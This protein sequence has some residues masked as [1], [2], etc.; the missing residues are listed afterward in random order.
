[1]LLISAL[2]LLLAIPDGAD[3]KAPTGYT[4]RILRCNRPYA[5]AD[6]PAVAL[7]PPRWTPRTPRRLLEPL[8]LRGPPPARWIGSFTTVCADMKAGAFGRQPERRQV[9]PGGRV[10][11]G[12]FVA[13]AAS[14]AA[15]PAIKKTASTSPPPPGSST[16]S[17]KGSRKQEG[18]LSRWDSGGQ[19]SGRL[20]PS[21]TSRL[22]RA[23]GTCSASPERPTRSSPPVD[24][25]A[26]ARR[27]G[28]NRA[29]RTPPPPASESSAS[30]DSDEQE[31]PVPLP[32]Q[33][34]N[35]HVRTRSRSS[36]SPTRVQPPARQRVSRDEEDGDRRRG[37]QRTSSPHRQEPSKSD[38]VEGTAPTRPAPRP[39]PGLLSSLWNRASELVAGNAPAAAAGPSDEAASSSNKPGAEGEEEGADEADKVERSEADTTRRGKRPARPVVVPALVAPALAGVLPNA[40]VAPAPARS[41]APSLPPPEPITYHR[42]PA[43]HPRLN[44]EE[45]P[46]FRSQPTPY[47]WL[48]AR[49]ESRLLPYMFLP[50]AAQAAAYEARVRAQANKAAAPHAAAAAVSAPWPVAAPTSSAPPQAQA[51]LAASLHPYV[52]QPFR[53]S[54][55]VGTALIP[56]RVQISHG[57]GRSVDASARF[58]TRT[59]DRGETRRPRLRSA[60]PSTATPGTNPIK[61]CERRTAGRWRTRARRRHRKQYRYTSTSRPVRLCLPADQRTG[62]QLGCRFP[63]HHREL[64]SSRVRLCSTGTRTGAGASLWIPSSC[65]FPC[66]CTGCCICGRGV[67]CADGARATGRVLASLYRDRASASPCITRDSPNHDFSRRGIASAVGVCGHSGCWRH[68]RSNRRLFCAARFGDPTSWTRWRFVA[69]SSFP[70]TVLCGGAF[71]RASRT[72][73]YIRSH[74]TRTGRCSLGNGTDADRIFGLGVG[75]RAYFGYR[76]F[77]SRRYYHSA[78]ITTAASKSPSARPSRQFPRL[79]V[80]GG[81]VRTFAYVDNISG[82]V[83]QPGRTARS[84]TTVPRS[85]CAAERSENGAQAS[86]PRDGSRGGRLCLAVT[87]CSARERTEYRRST[88]RTRQQRRLAADAEASANS[89]LASSAVRPDH[90]LAIVLRPAHNSASELYAT[91]AHPLCIRSAG[92]DTL[93]G[94][95]RRGCAGAD[96]SDEIDLV[97]CNEAVALQQ[98]GAVR[99][100]E[101]ASS[102]RIRCST[103]RPRRRPKGR[104][105]RYS[106]HRVKPFYCVCRH[107]V[108]LS[109]DD[110]SDHGHTAP[111]SARSRQV[112]VAHFAQ[113]AT[114]AASSGEHSS[115]TGSVFVR[116]FP[117]VS[118]TS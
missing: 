58:A 20:P 50:T 47:D 4:T 90:Q 107:V 51:P 18:V 94:R 13:P 1:M 45:S 91:S 36:S 88:S 44:H 110:S 73:L 10:L 100:G 55:F 7:E 118:V 33:Q 64:R 5:R 16:S 59:T 42:S 105:S 15:A 71:S 111:P 95:S 84:S 69:D 101:C 74:G 21:T 37:A 24:S 22:D 116:P 38:A 81:T 114:G 17:P 57:H 89:R 66:R 83:R 60:G 2:N 108:L 27:L 72:V 109:R 78:I 48:D 85:G 32:N 63:G 76:N 98:P 8:Q 30:S 12:M 106:Q 19:G 28:L 93:A 82:F 79:A 43:L 62:A 34:S 115:S 3:R 49:D 102:S 46:R 23:L 25:I 99:V 104:H 70:G 40:T 113:S 41:S 52:S 86:R 112:T 96:H 65:P 77:R 9:Q 35:R 87:S 56:A 53:P 61:L 14:A 11:P 80:G 92:C 117:D 54:S 29:P 31:T 67:R 39:L 75:Q 68:C 6:P 97:A 26:R 103:S